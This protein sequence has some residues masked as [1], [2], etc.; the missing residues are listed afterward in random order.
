MVPKVGLEPTRL[1]PKVFETSLS[2]DS[3]IR[4][5]K[6]RSVV[7][8]YPDMVLLDYPYSTNFNARSISCLRLPF[9]AFGG[10]DAG[11]LSAGRCNYDF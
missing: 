5:Y 11:R 1:A 2:A 9:K 4:A 3:S 8:N 6:C 10:L 7:K